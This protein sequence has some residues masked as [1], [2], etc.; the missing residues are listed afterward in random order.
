MWETNEKC[1]HSRPPGYQRLVLFGMRRGEALIPL[2]KQHNLKWLS[3]TRTKPTVG[4]YLCRFFSDSKTWVRMSGYEE[5]AM[6]ALWPAQASWRVTL[7]LVPWNFA[8]SSCLQPYYQPSL[9]KILQIPCEEMFGP[10][11]GLLWMCVGPLAPTQKV[12]CRYLKDL[13]RKRTNIPQVSNNLH[14]PR[15]W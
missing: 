11:K 4:I 14:C 1:G 5:G 13:D 9:P 7:L 8:T 3:P 12:F 10:C 6:S 15:K 2:K